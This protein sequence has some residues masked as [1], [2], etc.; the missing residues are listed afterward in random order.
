MSGSSW[1][2]AFVCWCHTTAS[3][4]RSLIALLKASGF[5]QLMLVGLVQN[6]VLHFLFQAECTCY[7][8]TLACSRAVFS[9][10]ENQSCFRRTFLA[11]GKRHVWGHT[12]ISTSQ[13]TQARGEEEWSGANAIIIIPRPCRIKRAGNHVYEENWF[14]KIWLSSLCKEVLWWGNEQKDGI[15]K[16]I[17][18][19]LDWA[20]CSWHGQIWTK[21]LTPLRTVSSMCAPFWNKQ[22]FRTCL[23]P[24]KWGNDP[25]SLVL[26]PGILADYDSWGAQSLQ[27]G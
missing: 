16:F 27:L 22:L 14:F 10:M 18:P 21:F 5:A 8:K 11:T 25:W 2:P 1:N 20:S 15:R 13:L 24:R 12:L 26:I 9:A 19:N 3:R 7:Y 23:S 4:S 6:M 17:F